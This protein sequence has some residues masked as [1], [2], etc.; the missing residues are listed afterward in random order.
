MDDGI[1]DPRLTEPGPEEKPLNIIWAAFFAATV[2]YAAV[3]WLLDQTPRDPI[4]QE[5]LNWVQIFLGMSS[6]L[7]I[8]VA[9]LLRQ[10]IAALS[11]HSYRNYCIIRWVLLETIGVFG[12]VQFM[13]GGYFEVLM[14]FIAVAL[15]SLGAA[16]PGLADRAAF[17]HQFS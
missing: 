7:L 4:N 13:L 2:I 6:G 17:V 3:G 1:P 15:L 16:R 8:L 11:G 14:L 12:L 5:I 9:F 10:A